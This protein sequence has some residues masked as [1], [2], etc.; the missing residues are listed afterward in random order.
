MNDEINPK[1]R[2]GAK[3]VNLF[4]VPAA[5][6]IYQ[7]LAMEDGAR[8]YGPYNWRDKKVQL[9]IYLSA[10]ERHIEA[11]KDGEETATD[12]GLPHLAHAIANI[13]IIIDALESGCLVDDRPKKGAA[14]QLI[15]RF[16]K[17]EQSNATIPFG[18]H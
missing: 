17:K 11:F 5:S 7:A 6:K 4:L 15:E 10:L 9:S 8:K 12:S 3:K 13:G 14:P 2:L 16:T 1:D 18:V